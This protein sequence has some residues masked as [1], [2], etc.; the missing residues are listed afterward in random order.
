M[1][2]SKAKHKVTTAHP[3]APQNHVGLNRAH[4]YLEASSLILLTQ[5]L[6]GAKA[7]SGL[8]RTVPR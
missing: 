4:G 7:G 1:N 5:S 8:E 6:Q 3:T 2:I